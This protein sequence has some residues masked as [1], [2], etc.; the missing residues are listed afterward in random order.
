MDNCIFCKI[1]NKQIPANIV[2]EDEKL[3]AFLDINPFNKGHVLIIPKKHF[4]KLHL[5]DDLYL[6]DVLKVAKKIAIA[7]MKA[8]NT[9]KYNLLVYGDDVDH[10]HIHVYPRFINDD[11]KLWGHK[12]YKEG[13]IEETAEKI[14]AFLS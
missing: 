9:E 3:L 4:A 1:I 11:I 7:Q 8:F 13:E 5:T 14:R 10:F 12:S 2:Y 6:E